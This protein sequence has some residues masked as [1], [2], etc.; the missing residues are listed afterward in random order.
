[1][2]RMLHYVWLHRIFPIG[3][4]CT[5]DGCSVEVIY[6][7]LH[8][9]DAGP[10][11]LNAQVR[12]D[13]VLW[14]GNVEIHLKSSDWYRHHHDKDVNFNSVILHVTSLADCE[15]LCCNGTKVP[16]LLLDIPAD[17]REN[18]DILCGHDRIP[19]CRAVL[20][21]LPAMSVHSWMS[22]LFVERME[23]RVE[24]IMERWEA[25]DR[26]WEDAMFVTVARNFGFGLNG[27][28]FETWARHIPMG[29]VGKH[30]NDLFQIEAIFFGQAGF[31]SSD[32]ISSK[33]NEIADDYYLRLC[34]EYAYL[35][36]KFSLNPMNPSLW[37]F[38]RLRPQNFPH[39]RIAQL[40][41]MYYEGKVTMSSLMNYGSVG[42]LYDLLDTRVSEYWQTHYT[43]NSS[44]TK[45]S[46]K[47]LTVQSRQLLVINSVVPM[48]FAYGIYKSDD[49]LRQKAVDLME[50]LPPEDNRYIRDWKSAGIICESAADSQALIQLTKNYCLKRDCLRCRFGNEFIRRT[51]G[52]M[53]EK[54]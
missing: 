17:V 40:A 38:L 25:C 54:E 20:G 44:A 53:R 9:A 4:L 7:G 37:R 22:A 13:G 29:A 11:F 2:E 31:L 8:N 26:S 1:M 39:I 16:Q 48:L 50:Q 19:R 51:P 41:M 28:A 12:I 14:V 5:T 23:Q 18:Y 21:D 33:K 47:K 52:F 49:L 3:R 35:R 30:R 43:F 6:P 15:V 24:Q 36:C 10:D 42:G 32:A 27:S 45:S 34:S 46:E